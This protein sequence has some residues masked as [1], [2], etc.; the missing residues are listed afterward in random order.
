MK[1][2]SPSSGLIKKFVIVLMIFLIISGVFSLFQ[3]PEQKKDIS[4]TQL[5]R[6]INEESIEKKI[7][8]A[9]CRERV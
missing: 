8:R 4:L 6:D 5:I 3:N 1:K 7:G 9:S 2:N